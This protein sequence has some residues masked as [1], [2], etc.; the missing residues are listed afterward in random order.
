M[1]KKETETIID[2]DV[3]KND[4]TNITLTDLMAATAFLGYA[5]NNYEGLHIPEGKNLGD[6]VAYESY[7]WAKAMVEGR[8]KFQ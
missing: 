5:I 2:V 6:V 4:T 8:N 3:I 7:A 1:S